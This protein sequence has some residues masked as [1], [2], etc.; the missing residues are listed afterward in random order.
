MSP[1][2]ERRKGNTGLSCPG[3][4]LASQQIKAGLLVKSE[5]KKRETLFTRVKGFQSCP[6]YKD[7]KFLVTCLPEKK[8]DV[9]LKPPVKCGS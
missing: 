5:N 9:V 6:N 4:K 7:N 2:T 8:N 1:V 3:R